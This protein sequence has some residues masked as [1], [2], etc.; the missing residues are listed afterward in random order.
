MKKCKVLSKAL[1]EVWFTCPDLL[2]SGHCLSFLSTSSLSE[3]CSLATLDWSR[4]GYLTVGEPTVSLPWKI[5]G[6]KAGVREGRETERD[7]DKEEM[8]H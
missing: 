5:K 3:N 6:R 1:A 4:D 2:S 8:K 7:R